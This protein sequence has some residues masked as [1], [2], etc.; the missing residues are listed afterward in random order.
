MDFF[1]LNEKITVKFETEFKRNERVIIVNVGKYD[2]EFNSNF[3]RYK[4]FIGEIKSKKK[5][6]NCSKFPFLSKWDYN[7]LIEARNDFFKTNTISING[8][9]LKKLNEFDTDNIP[10]N[11][12]KRMKL[13]TDGSIG[14]GNNPT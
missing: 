8:S 14:T 13:S 3:L 4:G 5:C 7:V 10:D 6:N 11:F 9:F 12:V 1:S 2:K